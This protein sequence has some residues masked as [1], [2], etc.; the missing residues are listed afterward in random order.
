MLLSRSALPP[1]LSCI[2]RL[3][4]LGFCGLGWGGEI[5]ECNLPMW[6]WPFLLCEAWEQCCL[7]S[8]WGPARPFATL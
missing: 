7:P 6:V 2:P 4:C 5:A 1:L 8:C 3:P